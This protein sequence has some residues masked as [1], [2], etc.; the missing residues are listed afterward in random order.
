LIISI[1]VFPNP[2]NSQINIATDANIEA[3][4][5]IDITGKTVKFFGL[6]ENELEV[7]DLT[8]GIYLLQIQ[9]GKIL[10]TKKIVKE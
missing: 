2:V 1:S 3:I 4:S 8:P 5:I 7:S 10:V 6:G 9:V